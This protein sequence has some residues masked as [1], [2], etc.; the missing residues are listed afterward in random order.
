ME[1]NGA[2]PWCNSKDYR[3]DAQQSQHADAHKPQARR[4]LA[5]SE[6]LGLIT[7][8]SLVTGALFIPQWEL[9]ES[10]LLGLS[11]AGTLLGILFGRSVRRSGWF[12]GLCIGL[13]GVTAGT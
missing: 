7:L 9:E 2:R 12:W 6:F 13:L 4:P 8:A 5:L 1:Q 11:V 10:W 3:M